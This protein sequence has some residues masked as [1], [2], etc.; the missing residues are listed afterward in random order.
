MCI[1]D[2]NVGFYYKGQ[3]YKP[4]TDSVYKREPFKMEIET[5]Y[6]GSYLMDMNKVF[7]YGIQKNIPKNVHDISKAK[8]SYNVACTNMRRMIPK[9][10]V[11]NIT[12]FAD[13]LQLTHLKIQQAVAKAK[14]DGL[15]IDIEGLENVQL[16]RGGE[17]SP[18]QIQDIY[19]QT[20]IMYYRSKNPEGGFQNPP[21]R[22]IENEIRNINSFITLYNHYLRMIRDAT[23]VNEV[24]DASTPKGDA[25]VGVQQQAMAAGNNA[26]YDITNASLILY[27]KVC[28]DI[29]KC[30][31]I[32]PEESV[33]HSIYKK[34]IGKHN[35]E[36]ITSFKDLPMY[37]FGIRVVKTM[38]EEDRIFLEQNIQASLA[39]REIDL[40][41][42]ISIRQLKDIDQAQ[43]LLIVRR[44]RRAKEAQRMAQQ[45]MQMQAQ[46]N[47]QASQAASQSKIQE[48][49]AEA[50]ID[51]QK[52]QLKAQV[53]VQVAA[54]MHQMRKEIE[55]IKAQATLGFKTDDQEFREKIE[56]LKENRKDDRVEKQAVEQSKLI[57]QRKGDRGELDEQAE[58]GDIDS[59]IE[60]LS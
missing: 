37:N 53:D 15:I 54:A 50:Q 7:N 24:M 52:I 6:G 32:V 35:M 1:R 42:A 33:L 46:A 5:V 2:R 56:V 19:E 57:S 45:N 55:T 3:E 26:L 22:S 4:V 38:S 34:A 59:I 27:K 23:G 44:K 47:A 49:Q 58:A 28:E 13:Q 21:I 11:S 30:I 29:V 40:E 48:M 16:G 12:G 60:G 25:L 9:S 43:R 18:L 17:L 36:I 8:L 20:G 51:A 41:D 31:Q 10:M 14:P 39:Q